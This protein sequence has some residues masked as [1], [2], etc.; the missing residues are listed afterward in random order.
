MTGIAAFI[1]QIPKAE[2]HLHLEGTL[3][4][5]TLTSARPPPSPPPPN[6]PQP[7]LMKLD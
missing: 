3:P 7:N 6:P 1:D 4:I 2:L 5:S